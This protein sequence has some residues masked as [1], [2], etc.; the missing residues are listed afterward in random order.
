MRSGS[1]A[2]C[3]EMVSRQLNNE[4]KMGWL[5]KAHGYL[6]C[7][8]EHSH[9]DPIL[10]II[11]CGGRWTVQDSRIPRLVPARQR[12]SCALDAMEQFQKTAISF[13]G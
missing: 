9:T 7:Y 6:K 10:C 3:H 12:V 4:N 11:P 8:L 1:G 13:R 2:S 5:M